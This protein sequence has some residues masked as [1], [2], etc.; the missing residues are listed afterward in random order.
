MLDTLCG[1]ALDGTDTVLSEPYKPLKALLAE[2][3]GAACP[4]PAE[5]AAPQQQPGAAAP[6]QE[7]GQAAQVKRKGQ[8]YAAL[9]VCMKGKNPS[10]A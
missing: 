3:T 10:T 6:A 8:I 7:R 4:G 2:R 5:L 1:A 9:G